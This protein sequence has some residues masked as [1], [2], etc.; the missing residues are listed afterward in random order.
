M[1]KLHKF[2]PKFGTRD[3]S[4]FCLRLMTY[5]KL[6]KIEHSIHEI[7]D[8]RKGPKGKVPYIVDGD[9]SMGDSE[10]IIEYLKEKHGDPLAQGLSDNDKAI[11]HSITI[12]L[13]ERFYWAAMI[14]PRWV[15]SDHH[16][17]MV[18]TWFS[19]IP[20]ILRGFI[21]KKVFKDVKK[22]SEAHG[23]GRHSTEDIYKMALRDVK[24]IETLLG[25]KDFVLDEQVREVDATVYAFLN[26]AI[27]KPFVTP[28]SDYIES[29]PALMAYIERVDKLA[30]G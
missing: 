25:D 1:L 12:M 2:V 10:L 15:L 24:S 26:S 17:L 18:E 13:T 3:A 30:F 11:A 22:A 7:M 16:P 23:I 6:A 21:T 27:T 29:R 4:P 20:G 9:V 28:V 19:M 5:L 8:P 14:H